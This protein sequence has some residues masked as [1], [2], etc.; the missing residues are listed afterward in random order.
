MENGDN[1][2][3]GAA[4]KPAEI[5]VTSDAGFDVGTLAALT[6]AEGDD[7]GE[8]TSN[9]NT[10][11]LDNDSE[12]PHAILQDTSD[13]DGEDDQ[14]ERDESSAERSEGEAEKQAQDL[15]TASIKFG[16]KEYKVP[17]EGEVTLTIDGKKETL[18]LQEVFNRASG[19]IHIERKTSELGR[20]EKQFREVEEGFKTR[21]RQIETD[22][23]ALRELED[24]YEI[25]EYVAALQGKDSNKVFE[26]MVQ[27]TVNFLERRSRMTPDQIEIERE[28]RRLKMFVKKAESEK[29]LQ[30]EESLKAQKA[31]QLD[32]DLQEYEL[33][34]EDFVNAIEEIREKLANG[35]EIDL[36][37]DKDEPITKDTI[38]DY[39]IAKDL[40]NRINTAV[41]SVNSELQ[42]DSE[43]MR[44][45]ERAVVL[46][47]SL[48][49][50]LSEAELKKVI[51]A[52]ITQ[53]KK[54]TSE[55]LSKKARQRSKS[56]PVNSLEQDEEDDEGLDV[57]NLQEYFSAMRNV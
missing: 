57:T 30:E 19:A 54:A 49:G 25:C 42:N 28:N 53:T 22:L 40:K 38:I 8:D 6:A 46:A 48:T 15:E 21:V 39:L 33:T 2:N 35:E 36:G 34:K 44:E 20:R 50:K 9:L 31:A 12:I 32:Q 1:S 10:A 27:K 24:P 29:K 56:E 55:N 41:T 43:F 17:K 26:E 18:P 23:S 7:G 4:P 47:E 13:D 45:V 11:E 51:Q 5:N 37:L 14:P 52:R 3:N 16:D